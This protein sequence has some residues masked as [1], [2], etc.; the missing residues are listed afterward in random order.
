MNTPNK[1]PE[2]PLAQSVP[3]SRF[4]SRVG[5]GSAFFVRSLMHT[6]TKCPAF[7]GSPYC[8]DY[9]PDQFIEGFR[10]SKVW[11]VGLNPAGEP[12]RTSDELIQ[13]FDDQSRIH[14][15]FRDFR[16]VSQRLFD[17]F[18]QEHGAAHTDLIKCVSSSWPPA[19]VGCAGAHQ[20][21]E[22]CRGYFY[23]QLRSLRP[24]LLICNGSWVSSVVKEIFEPTQNDCTAYSAMFDGGKIHV[25]LSGFIGRLDNYAKR[26][27]GREIDHYLDLIYDET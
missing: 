10:K 14:D 7:S 16:S 12:A 25:I 3:L 27:L 22:N 11:V 8:R 24:Q 26:R 17:L 19:G 6:C 15:Y 4:T 20:I 21:I 9:P 18:G 5:G 2:P 23:S 13:A 1:S